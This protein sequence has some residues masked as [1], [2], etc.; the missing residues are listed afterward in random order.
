M[1]YLITLGELYMSMDHNLVGKNHLPW[2]ELD[3][4]YCIYETLD[5]VGLLDVLFSQRKGAHMKYY[6][7]HWPK[8][9]PKMWQPSQVMQHFLQR[10]IVLTLVHFPI[11]CRIPCL[12]DIIAL[13]F[14]LYSEIHKIPMSK[15]CSESGLTSSV[16]CSCPVLVRNSS[17]P[18]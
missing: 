6:S 4:G 5:L 1:R 7:E 17:Q 3:V 9:W 15:G 2:T 8:S 18:V 11:L 12:A 14:V 16:W 10:A 13:S